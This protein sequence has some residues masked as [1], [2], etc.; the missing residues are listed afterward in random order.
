[1]G[2]AM[3]YLS[4]RSWTLSEGRTYF[5]TSTKDGDLFTVTTPH[6][7]PRASGAQFSLEVSPERT[8]CW[9][10]GG[11][12]VFFDD[13]LRNIGVPGLGFVLDRTGIHEAD[14]PGTMDWLH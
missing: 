12:K 9:V 11:D 6:G 7:K 3:E 1:P 14:K 13:D 5:E 4:A 8:L 2:A 10:D